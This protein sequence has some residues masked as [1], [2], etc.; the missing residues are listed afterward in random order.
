MWRRCALVNCFAEPR[1]VSLK[2]TVGGEDAYFVHRVALGVAD[3]VGGW[4][5]SGVDP[6]KYSRALAAGAHDRAQE[7]DENDKSV[8][9]LT[10]MNAGYKA[11]MD[12]VGSSTFCVTTLVGVRKSGAPRHAK[13]RDSKP[14]FAQ[15]TRFARF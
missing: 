8:E 3:G 1:V 6:S 10:V 9:P 13:T 4:T 15:T 14:L 5:L 12:K 7:L 11:A 2:G